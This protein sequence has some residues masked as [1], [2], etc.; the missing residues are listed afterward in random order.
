MGNPQ[1]LRL[2]IVVWIERRYHRLRAQDTLGGLTHLARRGIQPFIGASESRQRSAA[3]AMW[4]GQRRSLAYTCRRRQSRGVIAF[5]LCPYP[6][7]CLFANDVRSPNMKVI[8]RS[9]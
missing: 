7:T 4:A 9:T 2:A 6:T 3:L 5:G 1:E 8:W